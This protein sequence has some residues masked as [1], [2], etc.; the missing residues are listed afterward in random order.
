VSLRGIW[1]SDSDAADSRRGYAF[2]QP[3]GV[4]GVCG[5]FANQSAS[6]FMPLT[7]KGRVRA[8][9]RRRRGRLFKLVATRMRALDSGM[10]PTV[11]TIMLVVSTVESTLGSSII[12]FSFGL[13]WE[14]PFCHRL[15]P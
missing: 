4:A 14:V 3:V 10:E 1:A 12:R 9:R 7:V 2:V 11:G 13:P 5:P 6:C 15:C 8:R